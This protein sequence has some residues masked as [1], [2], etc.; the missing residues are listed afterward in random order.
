M[1][2]FEDNYQ[3]TSQKSLQR[4]LLHID[5]MKSK[6]YEQS[7][8]TDVFILITFAFSFAMAILFIIYAIKV[9][10]NQTRKSSSEMKI[11]IKDSKVLGLKKIM[12]KKTAKKQSKK[13]MSSESIIINVTPKNII[14]MDKYEKLNL[15][16]LNCNKKIKLISSKS[17]NMIKSKH[18]LFK[19]K[20][21]NYII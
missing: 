9:N 20:S 4:L 12:E 11:S 6:K 18:L 2:D 14:D 1:I 8:L 7:K 16:A 21:L 17:L 5:D 10:I 13:K 3:K 19:P 15:K